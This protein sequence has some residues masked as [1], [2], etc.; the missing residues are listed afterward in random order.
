MTDSTRTLV[1]MRSKECS[2][3][4]C[5]MGRTTI[6]CSGMYIRLGAATNDGVAEDL[7]SNAADVDTAVAFHG[8]D[9]EGVASNKVGVNTAVVV[10]GGNVE[11]CTSTGEEVEGAAVSDIAAGVVEVDR[12]RSSVLQMF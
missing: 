1:V 9:T 12:A 11:G 5:S 7:V 10:D 2:S 3:Y 4:G 6:L 8:G